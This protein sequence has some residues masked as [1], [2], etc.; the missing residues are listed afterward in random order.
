MES[1]SSSITVTVEGDGESRVASGALFGRAMPRLVRLG[2]FRLEAYLDGNLLILGHRDVPGIIGH[3]GQL[4]AAANVNIAQM[5]VGRTDRQP[6]G[7]AVGVLN[8]DS[9]PPADVVEQ[10][11]RH[12]EIMSAQL[13]RL[14]AAGA[15]PDWLA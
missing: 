3:I 9:P 13:L 8:L 1:F 15:V 5:V 2:P 10:V 14:P 4:L 12:P 7:P 11:A 6:G